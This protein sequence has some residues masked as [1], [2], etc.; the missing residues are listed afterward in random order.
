MEYAGGKEI[1]IDTSDLEF[2][3]SLLLDAGNCPIRLFQTEAPHT[4]DST[5]VH[6][7]GENVLFLGDAPCGAFPAWKKD[8][9]LTGKLAETIKSVGASICLEGH[10]TPESLENTLNDLENG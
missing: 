2:E 10:W 8:P 4:D 5:L 1:R 9:V 6:V 3:S 7:M